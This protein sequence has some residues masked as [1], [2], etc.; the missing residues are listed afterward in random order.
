MN[1]GLVC[2]VM[3]FTCKLPWRE[4]GGEAGAVKPLKRSKSK[5]PEPQ[6]PRGLARAQ[7]AQEVMSAPTP[8]GTSLDDPTDFG[9]MPDVSLLKS[10]HVLNPEERSR[11][12]DALAFATRVLHTS[13][14]PAAVWREWRKFEKEAAVRGGRVPLLSVSL[15]GESWT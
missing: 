14:V 1:I 11:L 4:R 5:D 9:Q 8:T 15:L 2:T 7:V 10:G 3:V 13:K 6:A 12:S